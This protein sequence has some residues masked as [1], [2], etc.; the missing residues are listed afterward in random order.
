MKLLKLLK[1][2][3]IWHLFLVIVQYLLEVTS[4]VTY[5]FGL[6]LCPTC[7]P[8]YPI[9]C[10]FCFFVFLFFCFFVFW[11]AD[12]KQLPPTIKSHEAAAAGLGLTLFDRLARSIPDSMAVNMLPFFLR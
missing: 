5:F 3:V 6:L 9:V 4:T 10:F 7:C 1:L 2:H 12:H 8:T 11:R